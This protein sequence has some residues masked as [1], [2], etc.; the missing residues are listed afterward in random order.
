MTMKKLLGIIVLSTI[1]F[2]ALGI[3]S[4]YLNPV[5]NGLTH[6]AFSGASFIVTAAPLEV[7]ER[8]VM[9]IFGVSLIGLAG[10][11]RKRTDKRC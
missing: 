8:T 9:V 10:F 5:F 11:V 4:G 1:I 6:A 7:P 2:F 3:L